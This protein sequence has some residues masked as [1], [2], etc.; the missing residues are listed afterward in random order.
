LNTHALYPSRCK[1]RGI[2]F[3]NKTR[4]TNTDWTK[5]KKSSQPIAMIVRL[6]WPLK[7]KIILLTKDTLERRR[8]DSMLP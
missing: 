8:K 7:V 4:E 1:Q 5:V 2:T 3:K 6:I